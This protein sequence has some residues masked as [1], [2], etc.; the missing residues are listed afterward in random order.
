MTPITRKLVN[1][2]T[3][4]FGKILWE[5]SLD[6]IDSKIKSLKKS[7][8][9]PHSNFIEGLSQI[10]STLDVFL[11]TSLQDSE[12]DEFYVKIY[13]AVHL[14]SD[15][16]LRITGDF[17]S[18]EWFGN[19]AVTPADNQYQYKSDEGAWYRKVSNETLKFSK[20]NFLLRCP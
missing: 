3:E 10:I 8:N 13:D 20:Y 6:A 2:K 4:G 17:Q 14:E 11:D 5:I 1:R 12:S 15:A 9:P 18:K 7:E 16:I 19:V